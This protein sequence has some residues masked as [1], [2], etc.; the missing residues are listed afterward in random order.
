MIEGALYQ[1]RVERY[2][3]G[4]RKQ[5]D[6]RVALKRIEETNVVNASA[7]KDFDESKL[8]FLRREILA[9]FPPE[10]AEIIVNITK[11]SKRELK[12]PEQKEKSNVSLSCLLS[13]TEFRVTIFIINRLI[14]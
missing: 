2:L 7:W 3:S 12:T 5:Y 6:V 13:C 9:E 10:V 8:E 11:D 14:T 1:T 4:D